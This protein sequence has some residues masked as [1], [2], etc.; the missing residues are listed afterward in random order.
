MKELLK[1]RN[2]AI[3]ITIVLVLLSIVFGAHR[4]LTA[5]AHT[6]ESLINNPG[7]D[8]YS[9]QQN[10]DLRMEA[11]AVMLNM[12]NYYLPEKTT[13]A[14]A[15]KNAIADLKAAGT[16]QGKAEA[17]QRLTDSA[18]Q[19]FRML[20]GQRMSQADTVAL[21]EHYSRMVDCNQSIRDN[22]NKA[23]IA[24]NT[25]VLGKF[26]GNVLKRIAMVSELA[27]F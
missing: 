24:Y 4:S 27:L 16:I 7:T 8:G 13:D 11:A 14:E 10:L 26:P 1:N 23:A 6:A 3:G 21:E 20:R 25:G 5:Q 19:V 15:L 2:V 9:V 17:N 12:V 22:Y 18:E